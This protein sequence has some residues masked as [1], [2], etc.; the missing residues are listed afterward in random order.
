MTIESVRAGVAAI[1]AAMSS[2]TVGAVSYTLRGHNPPPGKLDTADLPAVYTLTG[3]ATDDFQSGG[4]DSDRETRVYRVQ[5]AVLPVGQG[6]P[7]ERETR[8]APILVAVKDALRARPHLGVAF[9]E[10][11][12][13]LGDS[14]IVILPEFDG[15]FIGFEIRLQVTELLGRTYADLE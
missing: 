5:V 1:V 13:V 4:S 14:G 9:V 7:A 11:A 10:R 6:T 12:V 8:C 15:A 2:V 3:A